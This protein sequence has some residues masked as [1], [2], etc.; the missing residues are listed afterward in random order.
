MSGFKNN[1]S[2]GWLFRQELRMFR[3]YMKNWTQDVRDSNFFCIF[4]NGLN[5]SREEIKSLL[6]RYYDLEELSKV[7]SVTVSRDRSKSGGDDHITDF[8]IARNSAET[9]CDVWNCRLMRGRC[10]EMLEELCGRMEKRKTQV[11]RRKDI[12]ENRV[13][14]IC[15]VL[16]LD[17]TERN[18]LTY[19]L[20]RAMTC[21]D[22][23]PLGGV[24]N[25]RHDV[26]MFFAMATDLAVSA[27]EKAMRA[28]G[29]L[30]KFGVL[31]SDGTL[32]RGPFREY[33]ESGDGEML[34][35]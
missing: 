11:R 9:I 27:V 14:E 28:T 33:L 16:K 17:E 34:E 24:R 5:S 6:K 20:V 12:V 8:A 25:G 15:R 7:N 32:Q 10:R 18:V 3:N 29:R 22:E 19:A 1:I 2:D 4:S 13:N 21:F 31:D 23:Y 26:E 30:K 35:G